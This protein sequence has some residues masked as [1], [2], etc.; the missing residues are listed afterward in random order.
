MY[1]MS[2]PD[3]T[4]EEEGGRAQ[5]ALDLR[6]LAQMYQ[7]PR[8]ELLCAQAL[9]ES[10]GPASAVPLLEAAHTMGDGRLL[11]QCRRFVADHAA[12]VRAS[13]GVEQLRDLGV[14]KGLLG[15]ALD[16]VAEL[17]GTVAARDVELEKVRAEVAERA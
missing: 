4:S 17:K 14:A 13:G 16:Q 10:V 9:Q 5:R 6:E 1:F 15:D 11:A 3:H 2:A 12:E 7:V 8:L